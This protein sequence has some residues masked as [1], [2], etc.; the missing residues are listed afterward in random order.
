MT[1]SEHI[2]PVVKPDGALDRLNYALDG[3]TMKPFISPTIF[4][5][6][7]RM[8][9]HIYGIQLPLQDIE[10]TTV[11]TIS[12]ARDM[13]NDDDGDEDDGV[14]RPRINDGYHAPPDEMEAA[15]ALDDSGLYLYM[16]VDRDERGLY[17]CYA[18]MVTLDELAEIFGTDEG[19]EGD[20]PIVGDDAGET[21]YGRQQRHLGYPEADD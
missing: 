20:G 14:D 17:D 10:G 9:L 5:Q 16:V 1:Q 11:P 7:V 2:T 21:G 13:D 3:L 18:Q 8:A 19:G 6:G 15:F 12:P 4:V